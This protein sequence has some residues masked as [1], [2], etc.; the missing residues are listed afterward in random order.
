MA[1]R[2]NSRKFVC[3]VDR[4]VGSSRCLFPGSGEKKNSEHLRGTAGE[5]IAKLLLHFSGIAKRTVPS[6]SVFRWGQPF[7]GG[8]YRTPKECRRRSR[9]RDW[10]QHDSSFDVRNQSVKHTLSTRSV[11][12][13]LNWPG[14]SSK[15]AIEKA[16][17]EGLLRT[18]SL[19]A[20]PRGGSVQN[21]AQAIDRPGYGRLQK[22]D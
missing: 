8:T 16:G 3:C 5:F 21:H 17:L 6:F 9:L 22:R 2:R 7:S 11:E 20:C 12:N 15:E 1:S 4:D 19:H 13:W 10:S 14:D 18:S